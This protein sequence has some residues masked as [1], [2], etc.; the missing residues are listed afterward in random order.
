MKKLKYLTFLFIIFFGINVF[1]EDIDVTNKCYGTTGYASMYSGDEVQY[2]TYSNYSFGTTYQYQLSSFYTQLRY[3]LTANTNY[4]LTF[5]TNGGNDFRN[6][7]KTWH[8]Y[9][10]NNNDN[11]LVN[12]FTFISMKKI[13]ISFTTTSATNKVDI[14]FGG[15]S[16]NDTITGNT[17]WNIKNVILTTSS[18][19]ST[20]EDIINSQNNNTQNIIDN[21]NQNTSDIINNQNQNANEINYICKTITDKSNF[22]WKSGYYYEN[23]GSLLPANSYYYA[24]DFIKVYGSTTLTFSGISGSNYHLLFYDKDFN[25]LSA[26]AITS[27]TYNLPTNIYYIKF[28]LNSTNYNTFN[29][30][31]NKCIYIDKSLEMTNSIDNVNDSINNSNVDSDV[32]NSFFDNFNNNMHGLSSII[33][34]PLSSIQSL[35]SSTCT[36]L[37][38]P[39]PFTD[40]KYLDVPC[41]TE[42]YQEHIPTLLTLIQTCWYGILAYKVLVNIF[43]IV[44]GFKDPDSDKIEVMDL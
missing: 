43:G 34:I 39:I 33:T 31:T 12:D 26:N 29:L 13:Q 37:H 1:A 20:N 3:S 28:S 40:N 42:I 27:Q 7:F 17:N 38:F 6:N 41:M 24:T 8:V 9:D 4:I 15:A 22:K 32:G 44:K 25:L 14:Q 21:N 30:K 35:T 23:N 19:N 2:Q 10:V 36:P 16:V 5:N 11:D 18:S